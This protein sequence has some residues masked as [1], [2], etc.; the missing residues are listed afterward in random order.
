MLAIWHSAVQLI[1]KMQH[2]NQKIQMPEAE[3][4]E[5]FVRKLGYVQQKMRDLQK[6]WAHYDH[7]IN[8][9]AQFIWH[10]HRGL[11][12]NTLVDSDRL[13]ELLLIWLEKIEGLSANNNQSNL[14]C[15]LIRARG[16]SGAGLGIRWDKKENRFKNIP[17][18]MSKITAELAPDAGLKIDGEKPDTR[19]K[20]L[21]HMYQSGF[22]V[23][24]HGPIKQSAEDKEWVC[25]ILAEKKQ[26]SGTILRLTLWEQEWDPDIYV[27]VQGDDPKKQMTCRDESSLCEAYI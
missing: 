14:N 4:L 7:P 20:I 12:P 15:F 24:E 17:W 19:N 9:F 27:D 18:N 25:T 8:A 21:R 11:V 2:K 16:N 1:L 26:T 10:H 6:W 13:A 23:Q 22:E 3:L 5:I